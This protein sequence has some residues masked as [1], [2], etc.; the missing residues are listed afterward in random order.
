M[1]SV[2]KVD[3]AY[4][5]RY[6]WPM[7]RCRNCQSSLD[8]AYCPVCGQRDLE[9]E[10]PIW[11]LAADVLKETFEVDGRLAVTLKTLFLSP[12]KLTSEFLAGRR[13]TYT[14]PLRLY[15]AISIS[16]FIIAA[17]AARS[18]ILLNPGQDPGIVDATV[19]ANFLSDDLP[20]LMFVLL[21]VFALLMK[22]VFRDRLYFDHLIFSLHLHSAAFVIFAVILPLEEP[23]NRHLLHMLLQVTLFVVFLAY[24]VLAVRRVYRAG[25]PAVALKSTAVLLAYLVVLSVAI[26]NTSSFLIIAD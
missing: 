21:P 22:V 14:S 17:W 16:F 6:Q 18:G 8:S 12:G 9:L 7:P 24:F 13:R 4:L 2:D 10:R 19:Q 25:W 20:R 5:A 11:S 3:G 23:S 15:L 1:L 26:E